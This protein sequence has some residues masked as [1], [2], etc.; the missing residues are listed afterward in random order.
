MWTEAGLGGHKDY[1]YPMALRRMQVPKLE[2]R[3]VIGGPSWEHDE[4]LW[5]PWEIILIRLLNEW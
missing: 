5:I 2:L 3:Y 1:K 4:S